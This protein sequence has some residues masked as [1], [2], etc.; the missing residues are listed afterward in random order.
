[1]ERNIPIPTSTLVVDGSGNKYTLHIG[2]LFLDVTTWRTTM[3]DCSRPM[4]LI[5]MP[6]FPLIVLKS[7]IVDL[8]MEVDGGLVDAHVVS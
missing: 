4:M 5:M 7:L 3:E 6:M 1:M 2:R 8:V